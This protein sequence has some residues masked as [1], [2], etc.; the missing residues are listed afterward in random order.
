MVVSNDLTE[1]ARLSTAPIS[2]DPAVQEVFQRLRDGADIEKLLQTT[3]NPQAREALLESP[4]IWPLLEFTPCEWFFFLLFTF[5]WFGFAFLI[6]HVF[7]DS[8][9]G[10]AT[11]TVTTQERHPGR[12]LLRDFE[13]ISYDSSLHRERADPSEY[14]GLIHWFR[15]VVEKTLSIG[16]I[17]GFGLFL[18]R[19]VSYVL[20]WANGEGWRLLLIPVDLNV[21]LT[22]AGFAL[23]LD[24]LIVVSTMTDAPGIGRTLDAVIVVLAGFVVMLVEARPGDHSLVRFSF[25]N[26]PYLGSVMA[27]MIGA[28][29]VVRWVVRNKNWNE[30]VGG[31]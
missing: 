3:Y 20:A 5:G 26:P 27:L 14:R 1:V 30:L 13:P 11:A 25:G 6:G 19:G 2:S 16:L 10:G 31:D 21:A 18:V 4:A 28:L 7:A 22:F 24:S 9:R 29:F 15:D 23:I 17:F 8:F 12:L